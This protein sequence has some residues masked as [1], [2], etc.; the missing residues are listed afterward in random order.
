VYVGEQRSVN[1]LLVDDRVENLVALEAILES[2]GHNLVRALSGREALKHLLRADFAL[3]LLDVRMPIMDGFETAELIREREK[4]RHIPIIFVT[5]ADTERVYE[6]RGY[7]SG[8]IDYI[9]KPFQPH[10]LRSKVAALVDLYVKTEQ[11]K[12]Q[13]E[14]VRRSELLEAQRQMEIRERELLKAAY[15]KEKRIAETLQRSLLLNPSA[16][17]FPGLSIAPFYEP[18]L[19]DALLGGDFYDTFPIGAGNIV[20]AVGDATGKGL[21]AA[22]HTAEIKYAL[23]AFVWQCR[24]PSEALAQLNAFVLNGPHPLSREHESFVCLGL[25]IVNPATGDASISCAGIEPPAV[26]RVNHC[27][28]PIE[29]PG[30]P[31]G[32]MGDAVY[33]ERCVK[34]AVGD[35]VVMATDGITEARH[36]KDC[37]GYDRLVK[38]IHK[39]AGKPVDGLGK[40]IL[41][42]AR[43]F[44]G[45]KLQDDA[46]LLVARMTGAT[47]TTADS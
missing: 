3:I 43:Q 26:V 46:C 20:L 39:A 33:D 40:A 32:V 45:G 22:A 23:R 13:A 4:C 16:D 9:A 42:A 47:V 29:I 36:G 19:D 12:E 2:L 28:E 30:L 6:Q 14:I 24:S 11:I 34:L 17:E 1:I 7:S 27:V 25:M 10:V 8:A 35:T 44:A 18:A 5:G 31:I 37:F 21:A 15:A 38:H 41:N